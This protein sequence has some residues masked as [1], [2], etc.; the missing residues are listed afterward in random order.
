MIIY[1]ELHL[2]HSSHFLFSSYK[3]YSYFVIFINKY[4]H[5]WKLLH[6][7]GFMDF[8][9]V[10]QFLYSK[11]VQLVPRN[12]IRLPCVDV[13]TQDLA[14]SINFITDI[15]SWGFSTQM[16]ILSVD[17][18]SFIS[19]FSPNLQVFYISFCLITLAKARNTFSK[20]MYLN[21]HFQDKTD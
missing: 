6:F 1:L 4:L 20:T 9:F 18:G 13:V 17:R 16:I 19:F 21:F 12:K 5:F 15:D 7:Y 3:S 2:F 10:E 14:I 11:F 8:V